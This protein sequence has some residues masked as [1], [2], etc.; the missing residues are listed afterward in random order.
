MGMGEP[1]LNYQNVMQAI[2]YLTAPEGLGLSAKRITLSTAG[3][4]KMIRK[5]ADDQVRFNLALSLHAAND[6]KRNQI[7]PINESNSLTSLLEALQYFY[8]KTHGKITLEYIALKQFNDQPEDAEELYHFA[9]KIPCM[10]NIIEYNPIEKV[11]FQKSPIGSM[12][13]FRAILEDRGMNARIRRSR[14]KDI[15]AAC[16]QLANKR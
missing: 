9:K 1:L 6:R 4:S 12:E 10:I 3:I 16:G 2:E 11:S 5:L 15:D 7:M 13:K 14:G 8:Q